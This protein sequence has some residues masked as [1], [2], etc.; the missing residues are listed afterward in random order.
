VTGRARSR[1]EKTLEVAERVVGILESKGV[2]SAV[3]GAMAL[4]VHG[5]VR[6]TRDFDLATHTHP[7]VQLREVERALLEAGLAAEMRDPDADD[8]LGGVVEVTGRGFKPIQIVN[9]LNPLSGQSTQLG[10]EAIDESLAGLVGESRLRVVTLPHLVALKLYAGG[11]RSRNDVIELLER[12]Q[13]VD[14]EKIRA[15][16][17]RHGL[18]ADLEKVIAD[19]GLER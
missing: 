19:L 5:Y 17:A 7:F 11:A 9:F 13:P 2:P 10:R 3:I 6:A 14:L 12:N 1:E 15:V 16:C 4:A 18:A 8:P